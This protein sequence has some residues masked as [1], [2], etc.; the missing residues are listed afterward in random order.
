MAGRKG[1][2]RYAYIYVDTE[3]IVLK[4]W[5]ELVAQ[6]SCVWEHLQVFAI[7][8]R[9]PSKVRRR[10][11]PQSVLGFPIQ[12]E[13]GCLLL[14]KHMVVQSRLLRSSPGNGYR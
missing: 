9:F 12:S 13:M 2:R 4:V 10:E 14:G 5:D 6:E 3:T 1:V 8:A 7:E 11:N